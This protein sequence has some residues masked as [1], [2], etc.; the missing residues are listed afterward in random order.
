MTAAGAALRCMTSNKKLNLIRPCA[1]LLGCMQQV[2]GCQSCLLV[3][4]AVYCQGQGA[5]RPCISHC[6]LLFIWKVRLGLVGFRHLKLCLLQRQVV[7]E[8]A[9]GS[10]GCSLSAPHPP[11]GPHLCR[12][13][14][15]MHLVWYENCVLAWLCLHL[16]CF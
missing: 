16:G 2:I 12:Y 11:L 1:A 9:H 7:A 13:S 6:S 14:P 5:W 3:W 15:R 8:H 4:G 10:Q